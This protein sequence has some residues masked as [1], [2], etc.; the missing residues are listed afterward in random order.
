MMLAAFAVCGLV[1]CGTQHGDDGGDGEDAKATLTV[2]PPNSDLDL[3]PTTPG[4]EPFTAT[5]TYPD[6][7]TRDVTA[8]VGFSIDGNYGQF[9]AST[10]TMTAPGKTQVVAAWDP[11]GDPTL[12]KQATATVIGHMKSV[13]VDPSLPANIADLFGSA[14]ED[15]ATAPQI[16]YPEPGVVVPRNLGDFES[17]WID[18]HGHDA[19]ELSLHTEFTDVRI[20]VPGNN[21]EAAAGPEPTWAAFLA[22]EWVA[23]VG[24]ESS[25]QYQVRGITIAS[26]ATVGSA[27]P[28]VVRLPNE[29]MLG[30]LYYWGIYDPVPPATTSISGIWRHDME[31]PG[32]A[33]EEF[34]SNNSVTSTRLA[35]NPN[36]TC[37]A[38]HVLSRDGSK[39]A[40]TYSGGNGMSTFIDVATRAPQAEPDDATNAWNFG[41]FTPDGSELI[42]SYQGTLTVRNYTD[43]S[44]V[45][46]VPTGVAH[47]TQPD[48]SADGH[49]LAF[50]AVN[51]SYACDWCFEGGS[52]VTMTYDQTT[53]TFGAPTTLVPS[54]T[55]VN[56]YYP[57]W[58]PDGQWILFTR[59]TGDGTNGIG[60]SYND[61]D[62]SLYVVKA[63]GSGAPIALGIANQVGQLTDSWGR[64]APFGQT[65]GDTSES[66]FWITVSSKRTYG[67]RRQLSED[68]PSVWMF[69]FSPDKAAA[70][71][72]PSSPA[73]RLPFQDFTSHNHIAQW[74]EKVIV[75]Q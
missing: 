29:Q 42:G 60:D 25:V 24:N 52:I 72:D 7:H 6:G 19:F 18:A 38:C 54:E 57:T 30:G 12:V 59:S 61:P 27:A 56:F 65:L 22:N 58:S 71:Q 2:D 44:V 21:G 68:W 51:G 70:G 74:T 13:R 73:F 14:T 3:T 39:M 75:T 11:S 23:A 67:V 36:V 40:I 37:V 31:Q 47:A 1:A 50:V 10:L 43:Q 16:V 8:E 17:H 4:T 5:A 48:L 34:F 28:Q 33:A 9:A 32:M 53:H 15:P 49:A 26:P 55:N 66:M 63:D 41:T 69:A 45:M 62:A 46:T 64:W 35:Q 20:Y